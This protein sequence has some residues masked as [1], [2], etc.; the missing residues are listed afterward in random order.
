MSH[1]ARHQSK[2][3]R[4]RKR[5]RSGYIRHMNAIFGELGRKRGD[6]NEERFLNAFSESFDAPHWFLGVTEGTEEQDRRGVDAVC[7]TKYGDVL[8]QIKSSHAGRRHFEA[9]RQR[10]TLPLVCIV[11]N[12][13]HTSQ[14]IRDKTLYFVLEELRCGAVV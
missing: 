8:V 2:R 7:H 4:S 3:R 11:V 9:R 10:L 1:P 5:N 13:E 14:Q 12:V 6:A